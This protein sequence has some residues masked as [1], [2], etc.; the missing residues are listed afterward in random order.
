MTP[1]D[2]AR[3]IRDHLHLAPVP[4]LPEL[5]AWTAH[6][7]SGLS[8]LEEDAAPYWAYLWPGGAGLIR[9]LLLHPEVVAGRRV[10]DLG[11]GS[12]LAGI[13]AA[14]AGAASVLCADPSDMA[15]AACL[16]NAEA[17]GV[18]VEVAARAEGRFD[19]VLAGDVFYDETIAAALWP[20]LQTHAAQGAT[21]LIGDIGRRCL[22]E[23]LRPLAEYEVKDVGDGPSTPP[24]RATVYTPA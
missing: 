9:H 5:T 4:G 12:G 15:R 16:L 20:R 11:A 18:H 6:P 14:R 21:V 22:P 3:F 23:G 19:I 2:R 10:L 17:N 24:C 13:A 7:R 8:I 1:D